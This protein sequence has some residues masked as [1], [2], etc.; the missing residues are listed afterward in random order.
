MFV[1]VCVWMAFT[2]ASVGGKLAARNVSDVGLFLAAFG[3]S[4]ACLA[5]AHHR[6][7][8]YRRVWFFLGLSAASWGV[9]CRSR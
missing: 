1:V 2:G 9:S 4:A 8:R 5:N 3:A 7:I 6:R